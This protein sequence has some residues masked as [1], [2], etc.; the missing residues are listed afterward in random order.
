MLKINSQN[1]W[2]EIAKRPW[3]IFIFF[4]LLKIFILLFRQCKLFFSKRTKAHECIKVSWV[5]YFT[6][7]STPFIVHIS[8]IHKKIILHVSFYLKNYRKMFSSFLCSYL[9]AC[10]GIK[11]VAMHDVDVTI[12]TIIFILRWIC[13][14]FIFVPF[15]EWGT[16]RAL[17]IS[18]SIFPQKWTFCY[19]NDLFLCKV[20]AHD[21]MNM[22]NR[23][24]IVL[25]TL[26]NR[27]I[28]VS[29]LFGW[30]KKDD[31]VLRQRMWLEKRG[32]WKIF[33]LFMVEL[34]TVKLS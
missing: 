26:W 12:A 15:C 22:N 5:L 10:E 2:K 33:S 6:I 31:K 19:F 1:Q 4:L 29:L 16:S 25:S 13:F 3:N 7:I 28:I 9:N 23:Y 21:K 14:C 17:L 8:F 27:K 11:G 32:K 34:C 20:L 30:R 24:T 18:W